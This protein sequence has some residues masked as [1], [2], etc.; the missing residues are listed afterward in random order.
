MQQGSGELSGPSTA[1]TGTTIEVTVTTPD[2]SVQVIFGD[3]APRTYPV[4]DGKAQIPV[5]PE[6]PPGGY[7]RVVVG[8]RKNFKFLLVEVTEASNP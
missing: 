8:K 4:Q 7:F 1:P 5:P 6:V 3:E 2:T